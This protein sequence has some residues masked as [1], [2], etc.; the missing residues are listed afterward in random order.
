MYY[1]ALS[2]FLA[3]NLSITHFLPN[4]TACCMGYLSNFLLSITLIR[5][6]IY[7]YKR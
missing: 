3:T 4:Q 7:Q 1:K 6:F 5:Y 2:H